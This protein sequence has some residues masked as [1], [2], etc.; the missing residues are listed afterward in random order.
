MKRRTWILAVIAT[1]A[2][3]VAGG[4][5]LGTGPGRELMRVQAERILSDILEGPTQISRVEPFYRD[6][7]ALR[8]YD[9]RVYPSERGAGMRADVV[10]IEFREL[11][12]FGGE[13]AL[14]RLVID[15]Y[16]IRAVLSEEGVW[17][18]P[19]LQALQRNLA[20]DPAPLYDEPVL[21]A[22]AGIETVSRYMLEDEHIADEIVIHRGRIDFEDYSLGPDMR[23]EMDL[24]HFH[25]GGIEARLAWPWLGNTGSLELSG[26]FGGPGGESVPVTWTARREASELDVTIELGELDLDNL[27]GY[28]QRWAHE[29]DLDGSVT[30]RLDLIS[31]SPGLHDVHMDARLDGVVP[32]LVVD[33]KPV[34]LD[35]PLNDFHA[36]LRIDPEVARLEELD[37]SGP[38]IAFGLSGRIA[39]P[40]AAGSIARFDARVERVAVEDADIVIRQL[41]RRTAE[42]MVEWF[43]RIESGLVEHLV[44]SGTAQLGRWRALAEGQLERLPRNFV[45]ELEVS[46]VSARLEENERVEGGSFHAEWTADRLEL[47]QGTGL[48]RGEPLPRVDVVVDG[49]SRLVSMQEST[50]GV[51]ARPTPGLRLLWDILSSDEEDGE[52]EESTPV[53]FRVD[54]DHLDHP[55]L[56]WP[57]ADAH[58]VVTPTA[59]GSEAHIL[60]ATWGGQP[61]R[62]EVLYQIEPEPRL[63]VGLEATR[64]LPEPVELPGEDALAPG[65][66]GYGRFSLEPHELGP[67]EEPGLLSTMQG[68]FVLVGSQARMNGIEIALSSAVS[69]GADLTLELGRGDRVGVDLSG[70]LDDASCDGVGQLFGLP[71]GFVTGSVDAYFELTGHLETE[72]SPWRHLQGDMQVA[73][74]NGEIRKRLP[75]AVALAT[76]TDGFNPFARREAIEY[77][78]IQGEFGLRDG[79]LTG[80]RLEI[81]GPVR[82]YATGQVEL[83]VDEPRIDAVVGV[84]L[85][86]RVREF[87][88]KVPLVNW[89][90]PGSNRGFVGAYYRVEGPTEEPEITVMAMKSLREELPDLIAKPIDAIEWLWKTGMGSDEEEDGDGDPSEA[91][92]SAPASARA[93][94]APGA[95]RLQ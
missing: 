78:T 55:I 31:P 10:T 12:L 69:A 40:V 56:R 37:L 17:D 75:L 86:Q 71:P 63:T 32:T 4:Y 26:I 33:G 83:L 13:L 2:I 84:F 1:L 60:S 82:V 24:Q 66:W 44:V 15:G 16:S 46:D 72:G 95:T 48:W 42:A 51:P 58:V 70:Q 67:G 22:I 79:V 53:R 59:N 92:E 87:L 19:P 52:E 28:I 23:P 80:R 45:M 94:D 76:A 47:R 21:Q 18:F 68:T 30:A 36:Q 14:A 90:M 3:V 77:E 8:G 73:A 93:A 38:R 43:N 34:P 41:P 74:E 49:F 50:R 81:E 6:G 64:E 35:L 7:L 65:E 61:V 39:R 11:G 20:D 89:I 5:W 88:D 29:A 85:L 9:V 91:E 62:A 54:I 25:L 57:V 27:D